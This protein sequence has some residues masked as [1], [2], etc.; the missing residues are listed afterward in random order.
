MPQTPTVVTKIERS[1]GRS[2]ERINLASVCGT[3]IPGY[4]L[5]QSDRVVGLNLC[6]IGL[7]SIPR[8]V[9]TLRHLRSLSLYGNGITHIGDD[10]AQL[11]TLEELSLSDNKIQTLPP[12]FHEL[13]RLKMRFSSNLVA[14][15][16]PR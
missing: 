13:T 15:K 3:T 6:H 5:A 11:K 16:M 9:F 1:I 10:I 12:R 2:L 4:A 7:H 8:D 14:H